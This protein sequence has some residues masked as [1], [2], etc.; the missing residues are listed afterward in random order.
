M[1]PDEEIADLQTA[2]RMDAFAVVKA[3]R[4]LPPHLRRRLFKLSR[5]MHNRVALLDETFIDLQAA[6]FMKDQASQPK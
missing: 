6:E 5:A 4:N 2:C 3:W 1:T